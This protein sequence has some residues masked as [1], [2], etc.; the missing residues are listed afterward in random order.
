MTGQP[1]ILEK[2]YE[3]RR[4][5]VEEE[6]RET[7]PAAMEAAALLASEGQERFRLF[8]AIGKK[9]RRNIIAEFKRASPSKG[10]IN[11][12][13]DPAEQAKKYETA[14]A[15]AISVLTEEEH[16][17]GSAGDL[18]QVAE[19]V[20]VPVLRKD[21]IF[22]PYQVHQARIIGADAVLLIVSMLKDSEIA[23]LLDCADSLGLDALVEVH[24]R[25][26]LNRA[27]ALGAKL[28]GVNNRDL[29]TFRVSIDTSR[30]LIAHRPEGALM[31]TESGI[32]SVESIEE[33]GDLGFD[34]FLIGEAL[35]RNKL[36]LGGLA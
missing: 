29:H 1:S 2:I 24:N 3:T 32:D 10:L 19:S 17:R 21:F 13:L 6:K 7:V 23:S 16:F 26:E 8:N 5:R 25:I 30:Q 36:E 12:G 4:R 27:A 33:L 28:I 34:G 11:D 14:G 31:I 18:K 9:G 15:A 22:D 35:M 20:G